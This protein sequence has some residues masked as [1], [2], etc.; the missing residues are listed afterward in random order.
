MVND[1]LID[2]IKRQV[3]LGSSEADIT[4]MLLEKKWDEKDVQDGLR[5]ARAPQALPSTP[6]QAAAGPAGGK[7]ELLAQVKLLASQH[8]I[9]KDEITDA[10]NEGAHGKADHI[11]SR[12]LGLS[13]IMYYIGGAVVFL[14]IA[15][16]L[17]QNWANLSFFTRLIVTAGSGIAAYVV[18]ILL[19]R[20]EKF[21]SIGAAFYLISALTMPIGLYVVFE[22]TGLIYSNFNLANTL[23]S[24]IML[25]AFLASYF[26]FRKNIFVLFSILF[27]TWLFFAVTAMMESSIGFSPDKYAEYRILIVGLAYLFLGYD[28]A[29][30]IRA[31]LSGFLYGFGILGF[32]GAAMAL[33]GWEPEQSVIW[34]LLFPVLVFGTIYLSIYLKTKT[35]LVFGSL[36]LMGYILKITAEYFTTGLG[37]PLA[38]VL[39]GFLL[40]GVGYY[41]FHLNKK[42]LANR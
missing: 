16:L 7:E 31:P 32:L 42:Y 25:A 33:G 24:G 15:I 18:G 14:G 40:M 27:G 4:R 12:K 29:K 9:T 26:I 2:F 6:V 22:K 17:A 36:F 23:I 38:L 3:E 5:L 35:F 1:Q 34:E 11:F 39:A 8:A 41:S 19:S 21:E 30:G 28:F 37:W 20:E 13:D 10:F